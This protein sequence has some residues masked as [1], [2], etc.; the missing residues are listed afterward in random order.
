MASRNGRFGFSRQT[1]TPPH[2]DKGRGSGKCRSPRRILQMDGSSSSG[3]KRAVGSEGEAGAVLDTLP[4]FYHLTDHQLQAV[5]PRSL[6]SRCAHAPWGGRVSEKTVPP[7]R[8]M[9]VAH[10]P[11]GSHAAWRED[12]HASSSKETISW[13]LAATI[14]CAGPRAARFSQRE[15]D[16]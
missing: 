9:N 3:V 14:E 10:W 1:R 12:R 15:K 6:S 11:G 13:P 2:R 5:F 4:R 7:R 16:L 8:L